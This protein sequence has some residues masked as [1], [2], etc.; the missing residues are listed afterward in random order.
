VEHNSVVSPWAAFDT[1]VS[2]F[3]V[4]DRVDRGEP[5]VT[6]ATAV[7]LQE[8]SRRRRFARVEHTTVVS[9]WAAFAAA[10]VSDFFVKDRV[11]RGE[12]SVTSAAAVGLQE[13]SRTVLCND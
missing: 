4:K 11:D 12:P 1:A 5:S 13:W 2:D 7:G 6:S 8:W 9:P 3:F 10:A